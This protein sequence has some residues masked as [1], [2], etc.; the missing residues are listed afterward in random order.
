MGYE[1]FDDIK[2]ITLE[3]NSDRQELV[4]KTLSSLGIK[5]TF[6]VAKRNPR[7]G[8]IGCFESHMYVI[9][10]AYQ[11]GHQK[12]LIFEDDVI[13]TPAYS[14]TLLNIATNFMQTNTNWE[15]FQLGWTI[16]LELSPLSPFVP[17]LLSKEISPHIYNFSG[18]LTHSYAIS[19]KGMKRLLDIVDNIDLYSVSDTDF[20]HL[21]IYMSKLFYKEG[22]SYC[23]A[24]ILF[25]QRWCLP[26]D[27]IAHTY[28]EKIFR[29]FQCS[30]EGI[31]L[32]YSISLLIY[33]RIRICICILIV[34]LIICSYF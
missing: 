6:Y 18:V 32:M 15:Y 20:P 7:G 1:I 26:T 5:F 33:Y 12:I 22:T 17:Y 34:L 31:S 21:D 23:I 24:P 27:N 28:L 2:C 4:E 16:N 8:R 14:N 25:D 29:L 11:K 10:E 3:G 9:R 13:P 19:R 30:V